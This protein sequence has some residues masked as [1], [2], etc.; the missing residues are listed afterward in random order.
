M[1]GVCFDCLV[2]IDGIA[3]RQSCMTQAREGMKVRRQ[4]G[5]KELRGDAA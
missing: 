5:A 4:H 2:E 1:M 3:S